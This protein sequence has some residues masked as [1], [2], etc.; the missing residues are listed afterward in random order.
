MVSVSLVIQCI[1]TWD[2]SAVDG[3]KQVFIN[4]IEFPFV[5]KK[6]G[7]C[8]I[9]KPLSDAFVL[10]IVSKGFLPFECEMCEFSN[11]EI[12]LAELI[13]SNPQGKSEWIPIKTPATIV[14]GY[15]YYRVIEIGKNHIIINNPKHRNI[16]GRRFLLRDT[17]TNTEELIVLENVC[18]A[19]LTEYKMASLK[20]KYNMKF[21]ALFPA[22]RVVDRKITRVAIK[23]KSNCKIWII[24]D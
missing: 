16:E 10:K 21:T 2:F 5:A 9:T 11:S 13:V 14:M 19:E 8:I 4:G 22:F 6:G 12:F 3:N 23:D 7:Y 15:N 24:A 1:N 20:Y 18:N 17:K